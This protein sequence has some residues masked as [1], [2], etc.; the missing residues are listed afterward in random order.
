MFSQWEFAKESTDNFEGCEMIKVYT[1][2]TFFEDRE[3]PPEWQDK[4]LSETKEMG[5]HLVWS[6]GPDVY[7]GKDK[8]GRRKAPRMYCGDWIGSI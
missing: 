7:S 3:N 6:S 4:V 5:L 1:S 2:G 8:L